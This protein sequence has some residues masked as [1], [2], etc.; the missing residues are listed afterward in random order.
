MENHGYQPNVTSDR[1]T[2]KPP[3]EQVMEIEVTELN[4]QYAATHR[5]VGG[6]RTIARRSSADEAIGAL[7]QLIGQTAYGIE[8]DD[9][10]NN[11]QQDVKSVDLDKLYRIA[12]DQGVRHGILEAGAAGMIAPAVFAKYLKENDPYSLTTDTQPKT[13]ALPLEPVAVE[14]VTPG[15][16]FFE[17]AEDNRI[18]VFHVCENRGGSLVVNGQRVREMRRDAIWYRA[19]SPE[20][21]MAMCQTGI[22]TERPE[23]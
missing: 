6:R 4:G 2:L 5:P 22:E 13:T 15:W 7:M 20:D 3:K 11:G 19:P 17:V 18:A 14:D 1:R 23:Q 10:T 21:L 9:Q 12:Y 16:Y 8:I